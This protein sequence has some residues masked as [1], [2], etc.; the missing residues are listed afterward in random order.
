M[1]ET[2]RSLVRGALLRVAPQT[3]TQVISARARAHSHR[4]VKKWG[5]VDLNQRLMREVG[6]QVIAGPFKG[7]ILTPM[8]YQEHVGPYLLGTY[9]M[10][11]H[12]WWDEVFQR[13]FAQIID[14]GAKFGYYAVGLAHRFPHTPVIAF[15][16]DWWARDAVREMVAANRAPGVS[17]QGFC[18]PAWLKKHLR[19]NALIISDCEG[20]ERELFCTT[21]IPALAGATMIVETH[22]C[23]VPGV[24]AAI[25]AR[26]A[27]THAVYE[28]ESRSSSPVPKV[29]VD[30]LTQEELRRAGNEVR[31]RQTWVF[32][33]PRSAS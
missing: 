30:S 18:S 11:L 25:V 13:S 32:L 1:L 6:T 29:R 21:E 28:V 24:L 16:T 7:L 5:L 31:P 26:F 27:P 17:V 19:E 4:L 9:E 20:Y 22:E 2:C 8:T 14:V 23:F 12:P 15:D 10:E 33:V 3:A